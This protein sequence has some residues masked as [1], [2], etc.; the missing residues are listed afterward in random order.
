M[1]HQDIEPFHIAAF[2][3]LIKIFPAI[4]VTFKKISRKLF[5]KLKTLSWF[6]FRDAFFKSEFAHAVK[7]SVAGI[8]KSSAGGHKGIDHIAYGI[9][10]CFAVFFR[11][12]KQAEAQFVYH[13]KQLRYHNVDSG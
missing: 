2:K 10:I 9:K 11:Q 12:T 13:K 3:F 6:S 8:K 1:K 4:L 7:I 5:A